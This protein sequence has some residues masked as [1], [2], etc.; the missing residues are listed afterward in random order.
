MHF[1]SPSKS[2]RLKDPLS[3][4]TKTF[5]QWWKEIVIFF[6]QH[7]NKTREMKELNPL[8]SS[9]EEEETGSTTS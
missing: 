6:L 3:L 8:M 5:L 2:D 1:T 7:I 4:G 9:P